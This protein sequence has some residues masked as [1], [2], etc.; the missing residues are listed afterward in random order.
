M[1]KMQEPS[2]QEKLDRIMVET[3]GRFGFRLSVTGWS[4]KTYDVY[5]RNQTSDKEEI[6]A[7]VESFA[8]TSGEIRLFD[9]RGLAFAEALGQQ[10]EKAFGLAEAVLIRQRP[11][12]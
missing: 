7:R 2:D 11:T 1:V 4:R 5:W 12:E 3:C 9:D 10:L 8:T 6:L